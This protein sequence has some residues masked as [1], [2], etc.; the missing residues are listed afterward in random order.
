MEISISSPYEICFFIGLFDLI[1]FSILLIV[2]TNIPLSINDKINHL[3][4]THIDDFYVYIGELDTKKVFI[5]IL[6]I[7]F[8]CIYILFGYITVDYFTPAHV[9]LIFIIAELSDIFDNKN[10]WEIYL[11]IICFIII[12]FFSFSFH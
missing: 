12:F 1:L 8:R 9:V 7:F 10:R 11:K 2:F 6:I 5:I 4:D 3:N